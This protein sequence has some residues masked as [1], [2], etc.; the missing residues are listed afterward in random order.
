MSKSSQK[1]SRSCKK[2]CYKAIIKLL[3]SWQKVSNLKSSVKFLKTGNSDTV[4]RR[5][6]RRRRFVVP[7]PGATLSHLV[8]ILL[9]VRDL[10][11]SPS[12]LHAGVLPT[13]PSGT[14]LRLVIFALFK[15]LVGLGNGFA[16]FFF[17]VRP[18]ERRNTSVHFS[19]PSTLEKSFLVNQNKMRQKKLLCF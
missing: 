8:K 7:R 9:S 6:R 5:R 16:M 18:F 11:Q 14:L 17:P 2:S 15:D 1:L 4:R 12:L 3:K 10:N 19:H 13:R